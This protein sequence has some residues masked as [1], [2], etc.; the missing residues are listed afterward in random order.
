MK[1]LKYTLTG[2]F[3][4]FFLNTFSQEKESIIEDIR[5]KFQIINQKDSYKKIVLQNTEFLENMTDGGG[6]LTGFY[7]HDTV[8]KI[9]ER[10][11]LS[12]GVLTTEYYYWD[13]KPI[14]IYFI[15]ESFEQIIDSLD[16]FIGFD[17]YGKLIKQIETR[18]YYNNDSLIDV[19]KKGE[20]FFGGEYEMET[21]D[22]ILR[23]AKLNMKTIKS[24]LE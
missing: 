3:L 17:Y 11:G 13:E 14:F 23:N 7:S 10:I 5:Q 20:A 15:E 9:Y 6:E 22:R 24:K 16:G 2:F 19:K 21:R 4:F 18:Y 1:I 12:Y 8:Y